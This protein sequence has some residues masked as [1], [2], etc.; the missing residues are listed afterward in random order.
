M[1]NI[2]DYINA[3]SV[4]SEIER[5]NESFNKYGINSP[6]KTFYTQKY[7]QEF[8]P[9]L[10][11]MK[12]DVNLKFA[13]WLSEALKRDGVFKRGEENIKIY[14]EKLASTWLMIDKTVTDADVTERTAYLVKKFI[15]D[16]IRGEISEE[17]FRKKLTSMG[18]ELEKTS[19]EDDIK[20][21]VDFFTTIN[22]I[23]VGFQIKPYSFF[24]S[25]RSRSRSSLEKIWNASYTYK[26]IIFFAYVNDDKVRFVVK[27]KSGGIKPVLPE[28]F[29]KIFELTEDKV[30]AYYISIFKEMYS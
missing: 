16:S 6:S 27:K 10:K 19:P 5:L 24:K 29:V 14:F 13:A 28:D 7:I 15:I 30:R 21:C 8:A 1:L 17:A 11:D 4:Y 23:K 2:K 18:I 25:L 9:K 22:G 12:G 3:I 26:N 20:L